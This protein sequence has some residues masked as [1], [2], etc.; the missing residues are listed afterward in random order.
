[1]YIDH[2]IIIINKNQISVNNSKILYRTSL[3]GK[4]QNSQNYYYI[5]IQSFVANYHIKQFCGLLVQAKTAEQ[6]WYNKN[7]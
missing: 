5:I 2:H 4:T 7:E 3:Q 6:V 1:M